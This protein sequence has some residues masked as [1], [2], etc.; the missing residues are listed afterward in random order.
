MH[1]GQVVRE[2][3]RGEGGKEGHNRAAQ[4]QV[5]TLGQQVAYVDS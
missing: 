2:N 3:R 1:K 5:G 4:R